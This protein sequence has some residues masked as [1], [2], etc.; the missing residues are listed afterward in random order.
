MEQYSHIVQVF[1]ALLVWVSIPLAI[2]VDLRRSTAGTH[3]LWDGNDRLLRVLRSHGNIVDY[4]P[5]APSIHR[6]LEA[7]S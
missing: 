3:P 7:S 2:A 5:F 4:V 1:A 6:Q